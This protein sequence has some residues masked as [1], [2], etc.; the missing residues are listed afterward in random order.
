MAAASHV[1]RG[2]ARSVLRFPRLPDP[3]VRREDAVI[4]RAGFP[5]QAGPFGFG[6]RYKSDDFAHV[7]SIN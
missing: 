2:S 3:F 6:L 7:L 5:D 4:D 1:Q